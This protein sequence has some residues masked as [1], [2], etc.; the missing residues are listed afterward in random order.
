MA[1]MKQTAKIEIEIPA[2][3]EWTVADVNKALEKAG[4]K[5]KTVSIFN[6]LRL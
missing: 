5:S 2:G 3:H 6:E 4:I 1:N